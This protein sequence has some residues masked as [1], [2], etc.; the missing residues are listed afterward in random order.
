MN[1]TVSGARSLS[2]EK[3]FAMLKES[4]L[5]ADAYKLITLD[6]SMVRFTVIFNKPVVY[7]A[8]EYQDPAQLVVILKEDKGALLHQTVYSVRTASYLRGASIGMLE[9]QLMGVEGIR[10]L[11]DDNGTFLIEVGYFTTELEAQTRF[12]ELSRIYGK[13]LQLRIEK[14]NLND[15]PEKINN[16]Q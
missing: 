12:E 13:N 14:R 15:I 10:V 3:D 5:V 8:K 4:K 6:D 16:N 2:A 1:F 11:K 9:E 7:E